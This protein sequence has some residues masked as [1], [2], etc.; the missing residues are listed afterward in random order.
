MR[1][2]LAGV[3]V[4]RAFVR[5]DHEERALRRR[6]QRPDRDRPPV[7]R[8]F[9]L[10]M[11]VLFAI[12][13]L[14]TVAI[15][16][17]GGLRVDSG[18]DA[19]RQPDR[20]PPVRH[21]DPVL[22]HDGDVHVRHG[23]ARRGLRPTASG[24]SSTRSRRS[25]IPTNRSA[26]PSGAAV[27][28]FRD[29]EFR[30]PGAEEPVLRGIS[31]AASPGETTAIVGSTGSGKSTLI[32]LIPRFYDVTGG[33]RARRRRRRP[34]DGPRGP[35][36]PDRRHPAEGIPV[37]RH[38]RQQPAL[39]R[40]DR[41]RR[42]PLAGARH[43]PGPGLRRGDGGAARGARSTR[44]ARTSRAASASAWRSPARSSRSPRSTSSTTA[45][46]PSTS[47]P[48][49][50]SGRRSA[51]RPRDATVIIVAQR[52]G[53]ILHADQ[54]VVLDDGGIVGIGTHDELMETCET[55]REIVYSQLTAEEV[56]MS[57]PTATA[58]APA[59][60]GRRRRPGQRARPAAGPGPTALMAHRAWRGRRE[61][62]RTSG[63]SFRRLLGELRPERAAWSWSSCSLAI[64]SVTLGDPR[65]RRSWAT[66]PT[67]SSTAWSASRCRPGVTQAQADRPALARPTGQGQTSPTC[68]PA[69][70][71]VPG[72]G[73]RLRRARHDPPRS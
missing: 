16:W 52:V 48:T 28:E 37:Q 18:A 67:C 68:S 21:A 59:A 30:Y 60:A 25:A 32:N 54:I 56:G 31:F 14:S 72:R 51:R 36:A 38:G 66:P 42:G 24:R 65:A 63:G 50:G 11:P 2:T 64:V 27:V 33:H 23:A 69:C 35:V 4:I 1:E 6:E 20:L 22:G 58:A 39:R 12:M 47:R 8:L 73:R 41:H 57:G 70:N 40:R 15:L 17:F 19:D 45:S 43:R 7:N 46:R 13:N 53:T 62:A 71:V 61:A 55:Y 3:R 10:M 34:R 9:A 49:R 26:R 44:A 5:T 29:V